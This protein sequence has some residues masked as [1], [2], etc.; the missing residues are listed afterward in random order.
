[1]GRFSLPAQSSRRKA[2]LSKL[3]LVSWLSRLTSRGMGRFSLPA[4]SEGRTPGQS[5]RRKAWWS[6]LLPVA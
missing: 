2:W 6:T 3:L 1:M 4:Q 5:R